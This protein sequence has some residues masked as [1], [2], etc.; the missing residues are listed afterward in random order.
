VRGAGRRSSAGEA[1]AETGE[2]LAVATDAEALPLPPR[3]ELRSKALG[4]VAVRPHD[5]S[6]SK[7]E[8][9]PDDLGILGD[10]CAL[11][12]SFSILLRPAEVIA[13][14]SDSTTKHPDR[15]LDPEP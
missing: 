13:S 6:R 3:E 2:P 10:L 8:R 11:E 12:R 4:A 1:G 7:S 5:C 14:Q 15:R 9:R